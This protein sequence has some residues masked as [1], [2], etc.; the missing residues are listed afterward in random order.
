MAKARDYGPQ[1]EYMRAF[2]DAHLTAIGR[3]AL[4]W[5]NVELRLARALW[6]LAGLD[7][8]FGTCLTAQIPNSARMLDALSALANLRGASNAALRKINKFAERTFGLQEQKN[9]AV[10]DTWTF[11]P[12]STLR[13]PHTAR[14]K[15]SVDPVPVT[16]NELEVLAQT[17]HEHGVAL[18]KLLGD[19]YREIGILPDTPPQTS[20]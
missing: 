16:T 12:G 17:I 1:F 19:L 10:H 7:R 6:A 13:W 9:R 2:T 4:N 15:V 8:K 18:G 11:D 3:V 14:R 5:A 20:T